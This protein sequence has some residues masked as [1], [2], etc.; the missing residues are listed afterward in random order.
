M[1]LFEQVLGPTIQTHK[2]YLRSKKKK[3]YQMRILQVDPTAK[4]IVKYHFICHTLLGMC[5]T[6]TLGE[7]NT[8]TL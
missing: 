8:G 1:K 7:H 5:E 4:I 3:K 6:L 2:Y